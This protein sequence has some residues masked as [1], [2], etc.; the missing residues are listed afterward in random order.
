MSPRSLM[1]VWHVKHMRSVFVR[2]AVLVIPVPV[3]T[4][5]DPPITASDVERR[6]LEREA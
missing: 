6:F 3:L 2:L 5:Q 1:P 4:P